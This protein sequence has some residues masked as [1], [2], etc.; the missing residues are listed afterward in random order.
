VGVVLVVVVVVVAAGSAGDSIKVS[1]E[2]SDNYHFLPFC[3]RQQSDYSWLQR[4][5]RRTRTY[6]RVS[7]RDSLSRDPAQQTPGTSR[8]VP[9]SNSTRI[10][11]AP[12]VPC[13]YGYVPYH[14]DESSG[15]LFSAAGSQTTAART[16]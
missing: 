9:T 12:G 15:P 11:T 14:T 10:K 1:H 5:V 16:S 4:V 2:K 7:A 8:Y 3:S 13:T 6:M